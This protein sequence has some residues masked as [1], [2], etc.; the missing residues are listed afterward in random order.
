VTAGRGS[1]NRRCV[2]PDAPVP[3]G[4]SVPGP[5]LVGEAATCLPHL[6][7][8][9]RTPGCPA[10]SPGRRSPS[11][12]GAQGVGRLAGPPAGRRRRRPIRRR[13]C[14][15]PKGGEPSGPGSGPALVPRE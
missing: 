3:T 6:K 7:R 14:R 4:R 8:P 5:G 15:R 9:T 2:R 13:R 1:P 12:S 10:R 11:P